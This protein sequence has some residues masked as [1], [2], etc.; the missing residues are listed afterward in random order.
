MAAP[1]DLASVGDAATLA[2]RVDRAKVTLGFAAGFGVGR[3]IGGRLEALEAA[4]ALLEME[5]CL[6]GGRQPWHQDARLASSMR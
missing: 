6:F 4:D 1:A 2:V 5:T 3:L